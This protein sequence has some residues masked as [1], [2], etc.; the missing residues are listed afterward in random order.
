LNR[1][2]A[3]EI[4]R[5]DMNRRNTG[6]LYCWQIQHALEGDTTHAEVSEI[7]ESAND[8]FLHGIRNSRGLKLVSMTK[9]NRITRQKGSKPVG[10][11]Y[12]NS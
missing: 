7:V 1:G 5:P 3:E 2:V 12:L 9:Q 10:V 6:W 8:L 4:F 11:E